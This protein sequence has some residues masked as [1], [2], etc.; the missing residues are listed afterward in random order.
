MFNRQTDDE[1]A[2][3]RLG[4]IIEAIENQDKDAL[5][6]LFSKNS[7]EKADDFDGNAGLLFEFIQGEIVTWKKSGGP[8]VFDSKGGGN[9]TKL[10]NSYYFI[11]TDSQRYFFLIDDRPIDTIN[12][13][14]IGIDLLLVVMADDRLKVYEDDQEIL[15]DNDGKKIERFGIYLPLQ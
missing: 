9:K 8:T 12:A 14:N 6:S 15:F 5:R 3:A 2:N 11:D 4:Q 13:D 1:L 10:I 7:L